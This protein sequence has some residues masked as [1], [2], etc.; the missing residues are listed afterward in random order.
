MKI[1]NTFKLI[2]AI[3][4]AELAGI[5]G[6]VFTTP[7]IPTWYAGLAKPAFNPPSWVFGSVWTILFALMGVALY[8][9]WREKQ[10]SE[11]RI[12]VLVF[13]QQLSLNVLWS[14]LFF[15]LH[16]PLLAFAEIIVLWI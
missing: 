4:V 16:N 12:A 6:S 8:L 5:I 9:I 1:N 2:I 15:G 11:S 10:K 14:A 3:V 7:S 13:F